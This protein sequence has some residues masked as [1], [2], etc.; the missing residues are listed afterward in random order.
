MGSGK[1]FKTEQQKAVQAARNTLKKDKRI[2]LRLSKGTTIKSR[3]RP[4]RKACPTKP[5]LPASSTSTSTALWPHTFSKQSTAEKGTFPC[6]TLGSAGERGMSKNV[7][8]SARRGHGCAALA[9]AEAGFFLAPKAQRHTSMGPSMCL[10]LSNGTLNPC[11]KEP[12]SPG[13]RLAAQSHCQAPVSKSVL[14]ET[15]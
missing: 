10:A 13:K 14:N 5:G 11:W 4:L 3:S 6:H 2:N 15:V 12:H 8:V 9:F 1:D 7:P